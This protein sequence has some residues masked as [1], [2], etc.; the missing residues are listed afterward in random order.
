LIFLLDT[1]VLSEA[2]RPRG[3]GG[4]I[5]W[6]KERPLE[7]QYLSAISLGELLFGIER[8]PEGKKRRELRDWI[9]DVLRDYVGRIVP[10]DQAVGLCWG[11]LRAVRPD[12]P[13]IDGQIAATALTYGFTLVTRNTKDF[14]FAELD[15][16]NPWEDG[17]S[18]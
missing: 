9:E 18:A 6:L 17:A 12:L 7:R 13:L 1:C 11:G 15:I 8:L 2:T 5:R 3:D 4:V 14:P 10:F 16:V